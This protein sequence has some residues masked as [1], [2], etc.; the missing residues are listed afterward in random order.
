MP[1]HEKAAWKAMFDHYVFQANGD[2]A[3]HLPESARGI[4]GERSPELIARLKAQLAK[5][6][7]Q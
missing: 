1:A 7:E 2:P 3:A 5:A 4:L 6:L